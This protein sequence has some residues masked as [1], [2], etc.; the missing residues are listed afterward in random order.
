MIAA[1]WERLVDLYNIH[2]TGVNGDAVAAL[3]PW[4][5][6]VRR[7]PSSAAPMNPRPVL[8]DGGADADPAIGHPTIVQAHAPAADPRKWWLVALCDAGR[9]CVAAPRNQGF[10]IGRRG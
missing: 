4:L 8:G 9:H 6:R 7:P 1:L 5:R 3:D 10:R 2:R